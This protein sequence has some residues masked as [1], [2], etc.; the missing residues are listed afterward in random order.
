MGKGHRDN[1][2][3]RVNRGLVSFEKKTERREDAKYYCGP[4]NVTFKC[5]KV[6]YIS[7]ARSN[8]VRDVAMK[9]HSC[10][11]GDCEPVK[12]ERLAKY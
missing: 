3:A 5:G 7:L 9:A 12:F 10:K 8:E 2:A 11:K 4:W 6:E 1:H